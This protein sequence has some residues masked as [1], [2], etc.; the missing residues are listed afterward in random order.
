MKPRRIG[1]YTLKTYDSNPYTWCPD[2]SINKN[3]NIGRNGKN[4]FCTATPYSQGQDWR[5]SYVYDIDVV[6]GV[7]RRLAYVACDYVV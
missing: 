4:N 1:C 7:Q 3:A 6:D 2:T 5:V